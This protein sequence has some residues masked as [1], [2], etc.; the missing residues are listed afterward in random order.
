MLLGVI[1][2]FCF[3]I[4]R[5]KLQKGGTLEN[6]GKMGSYAKTWDTLAATR[7]RCQNGTPWVRR[8]V[9]AVHSEQFLDFCFRTPRILTP[10]V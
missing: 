3:G 7:P 10:I 1:P 5:R 6:L 9:A 2:M 8:G 4:L